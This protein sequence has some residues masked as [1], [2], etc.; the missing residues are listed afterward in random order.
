MHFESLHLGAHFVESIGIFLICMNMVIMKVKLFATLCGF[1]KLLL[2]SVIMEKCVFRLKYVE[3]TFILWYVIA[4]A[5]SS[6]N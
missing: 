6:T 3:G 5:K 4:A 2:T 1:T